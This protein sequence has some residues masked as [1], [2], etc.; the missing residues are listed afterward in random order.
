MRRLLT[1]NL[2]LVILLLPGQSAHADPIQLLSNEGGVETSVGGLGLPIYMPLNFNYSSQG[3]SIEFIGGALTPTP[4]NGWTAYADQPYPINA[5]FFFNLDA[6]A[7]GSTDSFEGP[8]LE[9]TGK[10]TGL[11]TGPGY[12]GEAWRWSGN[13]SGTATS[14]S[15]DPF[16]SHDVSQLPAPLLDILNHPDHFHI[17]VVVD[18][19]YQNDLDVTLTFD[20]PS[21]NELPEP[22]ALV[23]LVVGS[24]A[25]IL[26]RR[27]RRVETGTNPTPTQSATVRL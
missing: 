18:G 14:A 20:A 21:P 25:M 5:Q 3:G 8:V 7:P 24:A 16:N 9:I 17:S 26:R 11:I 15:L 6:P 22:T 13:Y 19:G 10:V 4:S 2:A 27:M 12:A 1:A 23:T